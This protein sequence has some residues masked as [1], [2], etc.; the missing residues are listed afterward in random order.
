MALPAIGSGTRG[1]APTCTAHGFDEALHPKSL[2]SYICVS[3]WVCLPSRFR[4]FVGTWRQYDVCR[5]FDA[6]GSQ[7]MVPLGDLVHRLTNLEAVNCILMITIT[8][9]LVGA[10]SRLRRNQDVKDS[11][12][13]QESPY[14]LSW[15]DAGA[16]LVRSALV[17]F[18]C[19]T[20]RVQ[21]VYPFL[22]RLGYSAG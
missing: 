5:L 20:E 1:A 19:S 14:N 13:L 21:Y 17:P 3:S 16:V 7:R 4:T 18:E 12:P 11:W 8:C 6:N 15:C 9:E 10:P 2:T 22:E